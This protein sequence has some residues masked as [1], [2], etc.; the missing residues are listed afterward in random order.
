MQDFT[1]R[2]KLYIFKH[3]SLIHIGYK[4]FREEMFYVFALR[5]RN[6]LFSDVKILRIK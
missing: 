2:M 6:I 3:V 4:K 5:Y 1:M